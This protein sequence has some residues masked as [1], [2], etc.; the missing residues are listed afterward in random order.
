VL[1][2]ADNAG[3]PPSAAALRAAIEPLIRAKAL[4]D[5]VN[6][7]IVDVGTGEALYQRNPD[8]RTTPASTAKLLTAAAVLAARGPAYR[9][10]T[11]AVAG[12]EPGDVVLVGGGDPTLAVN[13]VGQFPGAARLDRLAAQVKTALGATTATPRADRHRA[14]PRAG[15]RARLEARG[16][17]ARWPGSSDPVV[18]DQRRADHAGAPRGGCGSA[19]P[20]P[21]AGRRH[22]VRPAAG[23]A[24]GSGPRHGPRPPRHPPPASRRAPNWDRSSRRRWSR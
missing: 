21:G 6:A 2:A 12:P 5:V 13:G 24:N 22:R 23:C 14:V 9:L 16:H 7:S 3:P 10:T 1:A 19:V 17:L 11:R 18:D 8:A 20:R 15:D 4:G